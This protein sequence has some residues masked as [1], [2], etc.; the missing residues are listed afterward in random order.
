MLKSMY[1]LA[2]CINMPDM[3]QSLTNLF[4]CNILKLSHSQHQRSESTWP[5]C[6]SQESIC[7][8]SYPD[9]PTLED[10]LQSNF[11]P[12]ESIFPA[13]NLHRQPEATCCSANKGISHNMQTSSPFPVHPPV[14][15]STHPLVRIS[16]QSAYH[17]TFRP[18]KPTATRDR[19]RWHPT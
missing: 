11:S 19:P 1:R 10:I 4:V 7:P 14:R 9:T 2:L 3:P 6:P 18:L 5:P 13:N 8:L 17:V 15:P 16:R 12:L